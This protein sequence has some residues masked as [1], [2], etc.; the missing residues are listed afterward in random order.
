MFDF[1]NNTHQCGLTF[2]FDALDGVT[3]QKIATRL[4]VEQKKFETVGRAGEGT[5]SVALT[6]GEGK[7][8]TPYRQIRVGP[9]EIVLWTG[10]YLAY[11]EWHKWRDSTLREITPLLTD[12]SS[13]FIL[14]IFSQALVVIP[15]DQFKEPAD[16]IEL[17]PLQNWV[18]GFVPKEMLSA[19]SVYCSFVDEVGQRSLE[20]QTGTN[21]QTKATNL[22]IQTRTNVA[23]PKIGIGQNFATECLRGDELIEKVHTGL[24][25]RILKK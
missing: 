11:D 3:I 16:L 19:G 9:G 2:K 14:S 17:A 24:L 7:E 18:R 15:A 23:D 22:T 12:I 6:V 8:T 1:E 20:L 5:D 13:E 25:A 10:W 21:P 4:Y